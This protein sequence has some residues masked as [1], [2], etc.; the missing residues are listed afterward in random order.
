MRKVQVM[1]LPWNCPS[2]TV[3]NPLKLLVVELDADQLASM[4]FP[5]QRCS[6]V[7]PTPHIYMAIEIISTVEIIQRICQW[8]FSI[9]KA[10]EKVDSVHLLHIW[11]RNY[12]S[13]FLR[14]L[15][16]FFFLFWLCSLIEQLG[17]IIYPLV[18]RLFK[19]LRCSPFLGLGNLFVV[20]YIN[21]N[22]EFTNIVIR[23]IFFLNQH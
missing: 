13:P 10:W 12:M 17:K 5:L 2:Q 3:I 9:P 1:V 7:N 14:F 21:I 22:S 4:L 6:W 18:V 15:F 19:Q 20:A 23:L 11:G 16:L 8:N